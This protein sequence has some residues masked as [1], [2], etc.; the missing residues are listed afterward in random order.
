MILAKADAVNAGRP[1]AWG[2]H[3]CQFQ[4]EFPD[5]FFHGRVGAFPVFV[6]HIGCVPRLPVPA[7]AF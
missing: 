6:R 3:A 5:D 7:S 2:A 1:H 4:A